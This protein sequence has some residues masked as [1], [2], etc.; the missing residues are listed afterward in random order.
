MAELLQGQL[1]GSAAAAGSQTCSAASGAQKPLD[2]SSRADPAAPAPAT[3]ATPPQPAA[4]GAAPQNPRAARTS[5]PQQ[6]LPPPL[7]TA[8][9]A[10]VEV[11]VLVA[12]D[13]K[14]NAKVAAAVL[15]GAGA[16]VTIAYDGKQA[17]EAF[18]AR[19]CGGQGAAGNEG[20]AGPFQVIF[21][22]VQS[23]PPSQLIPRHDN[24]GRALLPTH[25][26]SASRAACRPPQ[27][28]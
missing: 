21:M 14:L 26:T 22:D 15:A 28:R 5:T 2:T 6:L 3:A 19:N 17:V 8:T 4:F 25:H 9:A 16:N 23:A 7:P 18:Y 13:N 1:A 12:E 24:S 27:C 20:E 10:R 11:N